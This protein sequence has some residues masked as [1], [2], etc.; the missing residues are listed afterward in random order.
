MRIVARSA[1]VQQFKESLSSDSEVLEYNRKR[2]EY[3]RANGLPK[4][5]GYRRSKK[6]IER[7]TG[8]ELSEQ[9]KENI[10]RSKTG[11]EL[12]EQ[13]KENIRAS[14]RRRC[15]GFA[16]SE[17]TKEKI[18]RNH[19]G[20]KLSEKTKEKIK[21]VLMKNWDDP[22]WAAAHGQLGEKNPGWKGGVSF[23][24]Y[25]SEFNDRLRVFIKSRDNYQCQLCLRGNE[26]TQ[27]SVHHINYVKED[28]RVENLI[29]L[30]VSCNGKVNR[31]REHWQKHFTEL[32][33]KKRQKQTHYLKD[34][35]GRLGCL[36][37]RG[38]L[39]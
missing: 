20:I 33:N 37:W 4:N 14:N 32:M 39:L 27:L 36:I 1:L 38:R 22:I 26:S 15:T 23:E 2:L 13:H 10:R 16:L 24:P 25:S 31:N 30:C 29:T 5:T 6:F 35:L 34:L 28:S 7:M 17:K 18:R 12:S 11:L 9:H 19:T 21:E 8:V 3:N